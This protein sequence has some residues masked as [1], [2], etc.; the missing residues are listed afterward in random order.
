M[1][2]PHKDSHITPL[3]ALTDWLTWTLW[4][5]VHEDALCC[6]PASRALSLK[7]LF[8][9]SSN[10]IYKC[11]PPRIYRALCVGRARVVDVTEDGVCDVVMSRDSLTSACLSLWTAGETSSLSQSCHRTASRSGSDLQLM[12]PRRRGVAPGR[13]AEANVSDRREGGSDG[14]ERRRKEERGEGRRREQKDGGESRRM[15]ER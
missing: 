11:S 6:V 9:S 14:G 5:N 15:E 10:W 4:I 3:I 1:T 13:P 8:L 7:G 2:S 12:N